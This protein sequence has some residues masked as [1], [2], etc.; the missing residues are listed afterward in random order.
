MASPSGTADAPCG[1]SLIL[2]GTLAKLYETRYTSTSSSVVPTTVTVIMDMTTTV[3]MT[4]T[5]YIHECTSS[6][7]SNYYVSAPSS[8]PPLP[9][10][11]P[12]SQSIWTV[13]VIVGVALAGAAL[14]VA[15]CAL[16]IVLLQ[17]RARADTQGSLLRSR[18]LPNLLK[19]MRRVRPADQP[20]RL[21]SPT[22]SE[23]EAYQRAPVNM[24]EKPSAV[25][26]AP[27]RSNAF[28]A[29]ASTVRASG[30]S[31]TLTLIEGEAES[32]SAQIDESRS[33]RHEVLKAVEHARSLSRRRPSRADGLE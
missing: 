32:T 8:S 14:L 5:D 21:A 20:L 17:R 7:H 12:R 25:A 9:P 26:L 27:P 1:S 4:V 30:G 15:L 11:S 22:P 16:V 18:P 28:A 13:E 19:R 10:S 3:T 33:S 29:T 6:W 31:E 23:L 24:S 2:L